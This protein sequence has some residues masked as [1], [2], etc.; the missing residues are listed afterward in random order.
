MAINKTGKL[1]EANPPVEPLKKP[2]NGK[3]PV[4]ILVGV[5]LLS[6]ITGLN[7]YETHR[8]RIELNDHMERLVAAVSTKPAAVPQRPTGPEPGKLY[9]VNIEGAPYL[10]SNIAPVTIVE[11]SEFQ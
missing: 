11:F 3:I 2:S 8:Q 5:V 1:P 7:L 9:T 4:A 6:L 10:G